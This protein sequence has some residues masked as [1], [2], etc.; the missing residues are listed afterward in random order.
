MQVAAAVNKPKDLR[1]CNQRP[2]LFP[3][4]G[5]KAYSICALA[6]FSSA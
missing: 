3:Q 4:M 2:H 6:G 5:R 1:V